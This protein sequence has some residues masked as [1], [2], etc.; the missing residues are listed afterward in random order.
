MLRMKAA[1]SAVA[2]FTSGTFLPLIGDR[3]VTD[4]AG[5]R[6]VLLCAGKIYYDLVE[7]R[8]VQQRNDVAIVRIERLYPL[9][10]AEI[11]AQLAGY[12]NAA[13]LIWV[14]EEPVNM[15]AWPYLATHIVQLLDRRISAVTLPESSAPAS[16]SAKNHAS[17]HAALVASALR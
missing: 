8:N 17:D 4:E 9:P 16:G 11:A 3:H 1:V 13:E 15:G 6:R 14:Q 10:A 5:V 7:Q 2:D 12:P